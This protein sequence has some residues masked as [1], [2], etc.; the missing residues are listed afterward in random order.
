[1][2]SRTTISTLPLYEVIA[3]TTCPDSSCR[4]RYP[5]T[6]VEDVQDPHM[7]SP[8]WLVKAIRKVLELT[9]VGLGGIPSNEFGAT[10]IL[11][12]HGTGR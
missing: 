2:L 12:T 8:Q 10:S 1:V 3:E 4:H 7:D 11:V 6:N 9:R 5:I